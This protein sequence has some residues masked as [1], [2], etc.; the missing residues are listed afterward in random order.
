MC[1][2][3]VRKRRGPH[4]VSEATTVYTK[5]GISTVSI[6]VDM[7]EGVGCV[8][9]SYDNRVKKNIMCKTI[10]LFIQHWKGFTTETVKLERP[11]V[12]SHGTRN[13]RQHTELSGCRFKSQVRQSTFS[14]LCSRA[15]RHRTMQTPTHMW[16]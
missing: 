10:I 13:R 2:A 6:E 15:H 11:L 12:I 7:C 4:G 8:L 9:L 5:T 14:T 3:A 1:Q 16:V